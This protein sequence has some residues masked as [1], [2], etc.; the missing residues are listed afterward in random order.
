MAHHWW[1]VGGLGQWWPVGFWSSLLLL[2]S[3]SRLVSLSIVK[4]FSFVLIFFSIRYG[5]LVGSLLWNRLH[6]LV[7]DPACGKEGI[8]SKQ[9]DAELC[10]TTGCVIRAM[11]AFPEAIG[12]Q[13][14]AYVG[15]MNTFKELTTRGF[16][17]IIQVKPNHGWSL[18]KAFHWEGSEECS[19]RYNYCSQRHCTQ[20]ANPHLHDSQCWDHQAGRTIWDEALIPLETSALTR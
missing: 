19:W 17:I 5:V 8:K 12:I 4:L 20:W 18:S 9:Y 1:A 11:E 13:G 15:L 6:V 14:D 10:T 7:R 3:L 16:Q 2:V